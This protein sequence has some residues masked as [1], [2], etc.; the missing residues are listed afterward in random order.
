MSFPENHLVIHVDTNDRK[1]KI[2]FFVE[3]KVYL[4]RLLILHF[5]YEKDSS[6]LNLFAQ[7]AQ[8]V[9]LGNHRIQIERFDKMFCYELCK[10]WRALFK[11]VSS[12]FSLSILKVVQQGPHMCNNSIPM[13]WI[14]FPNLAWFVSIPTAKRLQEA[15][16]YSSCM[17]T[18]Y[19]KPPLFMTVWFCEF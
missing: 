16:I 2:D 15:S 11:F 13:F 7:H 14:L 6:L 10:I 17:K 4:N 8:C 3:E 1:K 5:I 12:V 19:R 18:A 9:S